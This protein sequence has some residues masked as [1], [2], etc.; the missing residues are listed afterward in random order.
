MGEEAGSEEVGPSG[1]S[2]E[3]TG[4]LHPGRGRGLKEKGV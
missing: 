1:S 2:V 3:W 4:P